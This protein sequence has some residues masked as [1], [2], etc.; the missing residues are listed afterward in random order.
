MFQQITLKFEEKLIEYVEVNNIKVEHLR[1]EK[2]IHTVEECVN[3]T[4]FPIEEIT[5]CVV[6]SY[7]G[8]CVVGLVPA[9]YR[10][11]TSRVA[12]LLEIQ[13]ID[14]AHAEL[15]MKLTG[16]PVGGMPF[17]G[18]PALRLVDNKRSEEHTSELQS[19]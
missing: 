5:K 16:Y 11:S 7:E 3:V 9:K 14:V 12:K 10:V 8:K 6:M 13:S 4:G 18:Y 1:F 19:H 15:A 2:S 17:M